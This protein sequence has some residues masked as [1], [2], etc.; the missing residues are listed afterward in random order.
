[1]RFAT[2]KFHTNMQ[3]WKGLNWRRRALRNSHGIRPTSRRHG[4][5]NRHLSKCRGTQGK[6]DGSLLF[7]GDCA[8][9]GS[10]GNAR[11]RERDDLGA[12]SC[13]TAADFAGPGKF[14]ACAKTSGAA[15]TKTSGGW[16]IDLRGSAGGDAGRGGGDAKWRHHSWAQEGKFS[17]VGGRA[18]ADHHELWAY[19]CADHDGGA[20]GIQRAVL[21]MVWLSGEVLGGRAFSQPESEGLGG[22]GYF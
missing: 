14:R 4:A 1:M 21:R 16:R 5:K 6:T 15:T 7:A 12:G 9:G 2:S 3:C 22:A 18:A 19:G 11:G 8:G 20:D 17:G 10:G 13:G